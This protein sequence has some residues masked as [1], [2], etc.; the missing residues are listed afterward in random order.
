MTAWS[1]LGLRREFQ[2]EIEAAR[3]TGD[4]CAASKR[5]AP[6]PNSQ[7]KFL[8]SSFNLSTTTLRFGYRALMSVTISSTF[9][10]SLPTSSS[11]AQPRLSR[12]TS[13]GTGMTSSPIGAGSGWTI[14]RSFLRRA[15]RSSVGVAFT[16][17]S[18][19]VSDMATV[20]PRSPKSFAVRQWWNPCSFRRRVL[21]STCELPVDSRRLGPYE[22]AS[23]RTADPPFCADSSRKHRRCWSEDRR[24]NARRGEQFPPA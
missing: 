3:A 7:G 10:L 23:T 14:L 21:R 8:S 18:R 6:V 17:R 15:E 16:S 11:N 22:S 20:P 19:H 1:R 4:L 9:R 13:E 12:C 24:G 5:S 2:R